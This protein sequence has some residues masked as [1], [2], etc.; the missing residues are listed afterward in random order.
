MVYCRE[1]RR[2]V[3]D[4]PHFVFPIQSPRVPVYDEKV[5]MLAYDPQ[6][7]ILE[8]TFRSG[9]AWQL[10]EV[11]DGIYRE[12]RDS[13]ISSF[14]KFIA[15]RYKSAPVKT[16]L[17]TIQVP[18]LETCSRCQSRMSVRHRIESSFDQNIRVLWE[19]NSCDSSVWRQYGTGIIRE[20]RGSRH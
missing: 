19:C 18:E 6:R 10:F 5:E 17:Q 16:G 9:Q 7:R 20:R 4:C 14:L 12:L 8:I 1:C 2:N 13:T 3:K 15:R 11:P